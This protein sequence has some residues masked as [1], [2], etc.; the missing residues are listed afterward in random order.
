[1]EGL[2][3]VF[4]YAYSELGIFPNALSGVKEK[5]HHEHLLKKMFEET[6]AEHEAT[7][8]ENEHPRDF[9]DVYL[10]GMKSKI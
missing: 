1:M 2:A 8:D 4:K 5:L 3:R 9:I 6:I 10:R 7:F